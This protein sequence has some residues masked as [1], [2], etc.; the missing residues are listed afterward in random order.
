MIDKFKPLLLFYL[1]LFFICQFAIFSLFFADGYLNDFNYVF[2]WVLFLIINVISLSSSIFYYWYISKK[3][4]KIFINK[5][6]WYYLFS[7]YLLIN[8][9]QSIGVLLINTQYIFDDFNVY[10]YQLFSI[11]ILITIFI[12]GQ[13]I[14]VTYFLYKYNK[15]INK[16]YDFVIISSNNKPTNFKNDNFDYWDGDEIIFQ[17][18]KNKI[19]YIGY[20]KGFYYFQNNE[21]YICMN[22]YITR[23]FYLNNFDKNEVNTKI[24]KLILNNN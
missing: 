14:I 12:F 23:C 13:T 6:K 19:V 21:K 11:V 9:S 18:K 3:G 4:K 1:I 10:K 2:C 15:K 17:D 5:K 22:L 20:S 8:I 7:Y 24:S 16:I